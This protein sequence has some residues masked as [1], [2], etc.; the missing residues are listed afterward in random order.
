MEKAL[1]TFNMAVFAEIFSLMGN[2][3]FEEIGLE[4]LKLTKMEI[5]EL[6]VISSNEGITMSE[7]AQQIGTSKV[8]ISR[9]I[10]G[11]EK[12]G[13]VVRKTNGVNR[14]NV[15]V[16]LEEAGKQLFVQKKKQVEERLNAKTAQMAA[17]DIQ[18]LSQSLTEAVGILRKYDILRT[19]NQCEKKTQFD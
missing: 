5:L 11:L 19:G 14:R 8:Q 6:V 12:A 9:S 10:S 4:D 7:L 17:E 16:Y 2:I 1:G 13:F 15:N 3:L 18:Q